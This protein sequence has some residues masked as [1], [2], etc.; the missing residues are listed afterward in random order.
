MPGVGTQPYDSAEYV[1]QLMRALG[2]DAAQSLAGN[3]LSDNQPYVLPMLNSGYRHLQRELVIRGYNTL[4]KTIQVLNVL[5]IAILD[6]GDN[7]AISYTGYYDGAANHPVPTLPS[8]LL[9]PL[10]LRERRT[11]SLQNFQ[12]MLAARDGLPSRHQ[13]IRLHEWIWE[14]DQI[15]MRGATQSNDLELRY[16][17]FL[18]ELVL[19]PDPSDVL[20]AR[21]ENALGYYTLGKWAESRGS[22]LAPGLFARGDDAMKKIIATENL[23]K[24][25]GNNRRR[26][27]STGLHSGWGW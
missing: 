1:L 10:K 24:N 16:A 23:Y 13:S 21:S 25:R 20:I 18:P 26:G 22:A 8:D 3:L 9:M 17:A 5:P 2:N 19:A 6:P 7:V 12:P 14:S 15:L 11:G 4:K 27:H